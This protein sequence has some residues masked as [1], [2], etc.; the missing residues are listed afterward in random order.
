MTELTIHEGH[1]K[2]IKDSIQVGMGH[3]CIPEEGR[4]STP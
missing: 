3:V 2:D 1:M 4:K